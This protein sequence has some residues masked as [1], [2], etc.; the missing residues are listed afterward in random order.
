MENEL[1]NV[2]VLNDDTTPLGFIIQLFEELFKTSHEEAMKIML[3]IHAKGGCVIG[4]C[5]QNLATK[6]ASFLMDIAKECKFTD[7][8]AIT[9]KV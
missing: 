9:E 5:P 7:F 6:L 4:P 2:V 1:Y 3:E 8:K